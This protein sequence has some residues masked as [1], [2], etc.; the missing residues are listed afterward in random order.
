MHWFILLIFG[1]FSI[2]EIM[3]CNCK[4]GETFSVYNLFEKGPES[5][6]KFHKKS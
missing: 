1:I 2:S 3:N 6:V 4:L 5:Q